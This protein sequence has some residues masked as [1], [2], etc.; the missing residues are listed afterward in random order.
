ML[1]RMAEKDWAVTSEVFRSV[2][3]RHGDEG[4]KRN[5]PIVL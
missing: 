2:C 5:T 3:S 4:R 1:T